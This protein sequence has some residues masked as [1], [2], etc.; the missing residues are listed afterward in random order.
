MS[1]NNRERRLKRLTQKA[2]KDA[3]AIHSLL[4]PID[5]DNLDGDLQNALSRRDDAIRAAVLQ[6]SLAIED[7]LGT[8]IG[9]P[10]FVQMK[11][12]SRTPATVR[13]YEKF[14]QSAGI[15]FEAKLTFA[16]ILRL[17]TN[18]ERNQ[19]DKL[20]TLRNKCAHTWQL[21]IVHKR[22]KKPKPSKRL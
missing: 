22:G 20:K 1:E 19:L 16:R 12:R 7:L 6:M 14:I 2:L 15:G 4:Y 3:E 5:G 8:L 11:V 21:D 13:E 9:K 10:L 17:I 18:R